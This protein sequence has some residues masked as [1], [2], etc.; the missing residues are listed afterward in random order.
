MNKRVR[1][2]GKVEY[3]I[4]WEGY[5]EEENTCEYPKT[6]SVFGILGDRVE[7]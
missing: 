4:K 6:L 3:L 1:Y 7:Q 5:S 2:G